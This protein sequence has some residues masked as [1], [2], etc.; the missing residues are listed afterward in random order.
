MTP[1]HQIPPNN[2]W[3][4]LLFQIQHQTGKVDF[5]SIDTAGLEINFK[6]FLNYQL[7]SSHLYIK[8]HGATSI[9]FYHLQINLKFW[10]TKSNWWWPS[11]MVGQLKIYKSGKRSTCI[12]ILQGV[13]PQHIK[14]IGAHITFPDHSNQEYLHVLFKESPNQKKQRTENGK[15][16][17]MRKMQWTGKCKLIEAQLEIFDSLMVWRCER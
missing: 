7:H 5:R 15:M 11:N 4:P 13:T 16:Q 3:G 17:P 6:M 9:C 1:R 10:Q 8:H 14:E 2:C 12:L